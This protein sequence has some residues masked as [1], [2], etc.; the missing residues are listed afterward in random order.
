MATQYRRRR[1]SDTWHFCRNCSNW[2]T[3]DYVTRNT[4]PSS[5]ELCN[6][7]LEKEKDKNCR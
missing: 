6:Q 7:C 1:A 4:R 5:H 2:P 3:K